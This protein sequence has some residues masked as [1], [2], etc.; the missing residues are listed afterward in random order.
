VGS[1]EFRI[2]GPL[3]VVRDGTDLAL[4]PPQ[5]RAV[6]ALL[7]LH[8]DEVLT[9]DRIVEDLWPSEQPAQA[10]HSV[11][12]Y[13]ANL[14]KI[15]GG[16]D[17][18]S[19]A[20]VLVSRAGGYAIEVGDQFFDAAA[21]DR[22]VTS[23]RASLEDGDALASRSALR[24][25]DDLWRG[26]ALAD[27]ASAEFAVRSVARLEEARLA[28][29]E[30]R[31]DAELALGHHA[32]LVPELEQLVRTHPLRERLWAQLMLALYRSGRQ[33]D[34]LR[35]YQRL[36]DVLRDE[37][38]LEPGA[39]TRE[40]EAA[41]L[42][43][44]P[45]LDLPAPAA[46]PAKPPPPDPDPDPDQAPDARRPVLAVVAGV[47]VLALVAGAVVLARRGEA[48]ADVPAAI[49]YTP[50]YVPTTC[51]A[52][53]HK[54][55]AN[56]VCGDLVVPEDRSHPNGRLLHLLVTRAPARTPHPSPDVVLAIETGGVLE[57]PATSP[58]RDHADLIEIA[59]RLS[60]SPNASLSCPE[61][62]EANKAL[63]E[64]P[65]RAG[66]AIADAKLE[67]GRCFKRLENQGVAL[68]R[69][70]LA[71]AGDDVVD[72]LRALHLD[73]VN[74]VAEGDDA[75]TAYAV[76][77]S[78]PRA[79]RS[80]TLQNPL[81][82]GH[83]GVTDPT[84]ELTRVFDAFVRLCEAN[85]S[86]GTAYPDLAG[87]YRDAWQR[88][89]AKPVSVAITDAYNAPRTVV[90]DGDRI[91]EALAWVLLQPQYYDDLPAYI[92]GR[93]ETAR[94]P[95]AYEAVSYHYWLSQ[96]DFPL[97][98]VLSYWCSEDQYTTSPTR[99][100]SDQTRPELA[101]LDD[102]GLD[103]TC[104]VWPVPKASDATFAPFVSAVPTF[105]IE[106]DLAW[107]TS[108][109]QVSELSSNLIN[110]QTIDFLTLAQDPIGNGA[111][112][113][114]NDLRRRFLADPHAT[115]ATRACARL[116]P[117]IDFLAPAH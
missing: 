81:E 93:Q 22:L 102:G 12:V 8:A 17:D 83:S 37:M 99:T 110:S 14:R 96:P 53:F 85:T 36:R 33:G 98:S 78:V 104:P 10:R 116:S 9:T 101:G 39:E 106:G 38:G 90:V 63:L 87:V 26:E 100:A 50:R 107:F 15:L 3:A 45:A 23:G 42:A 25:A 11:Q 7:L 103:W 58:A 92:A 95:V 61:A 112:R 80:L 113:C 115:L 79:I 77:R 5:Q 67:Y 73:H 54:E 91:T 20:R 71:D 6:L 70:T 40:L 24:A 4:G 72:L 18:G 2:L 21:F 29:T 19:S 13:V 55:V 56:G 62:K 86:C 48:G 66:A 52:S 105:I 60:K 94:A 16:D 69:Y 27:L 84:A 88:S 31:I 41:V 46:E 74:L 49:G 89:S 109:A 82:P 68:D 76:V 44:S 43:Q 1:L 97:A 75:L 114:L 28:A 64:G 59:D 117:P 34:A 32:A 35:A 51:P 47:V 108:P 57:N 65:S 30:L 111:P